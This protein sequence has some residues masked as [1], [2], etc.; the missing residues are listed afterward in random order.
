MVRHPNSARFHELLKE[1]GELHDR[2]Q[3]DYGKG[4]DPFA[5]VRA[6]DEW[7]VS[8]WIGIMIRITDKVR[9]LQSF[10]RKGNLENES[11]EDSLRDIAVYATIALVILEEE[12][13]GAKKDF[14][15][16]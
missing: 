9:R 10:V 13:S 6:S 4:D 12:K 15:P 8:P 11:V 7:G 16:S 14:V 3:A 2:K 5:N 1:L